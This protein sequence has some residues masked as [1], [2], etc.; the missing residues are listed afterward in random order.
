MMGRARLRE[1][2]HSAHQPIVPEA[3]PPQGIHAKRE[4]PTDPNATMVGQSFAVVY[5]REHYGE[6]ESMN[7]ISG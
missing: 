5:R 1:W 7:Q 3:L 6:Y 2:N 4:A